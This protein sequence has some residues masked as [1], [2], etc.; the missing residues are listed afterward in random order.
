MQSMVRAQ[1]L[2][3]L[4]NTVFYNHENRRRCV[5]DGKTLPNL[6]KL[7]ESAVAEVQDINPAL[8]PIP[9]PD[10]KMGGIDWKAVAALQ[11]GARMDK[12]FTPS[13]ARAAAVGC[14]P[15]MFRDCIAYS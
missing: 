1:G 13:A 10:G 7:L 11:T 3:C 6:V 14:G 8:V 9:A 5:M 4:A 12:L 15:S 2:Q